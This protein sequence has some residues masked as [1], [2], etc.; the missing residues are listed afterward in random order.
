MN[1]EAESYTDP[2]VHSPGFRHLPMLVD[3][4]ARNTPNKTW[5]SIPIDQSDVSAGF[6]DISY[7]EFNDAIS[8][9][10]HWLA[11]ILDTTENLETVAY[12][13]PR[14]IRYPILAMAMAKLEKKLMLPSPIAT[15]EAQA[16]LLREMEC[17]T[18]LYGGNLGGIV[19]GAAAKVQEWKIKVLEVPELDTWLKA[20]KSEP[21]KWRKS[22][23][24]ARH[25]PWIVTHSSGSTGLPKPMA[26]THQMMTSFEATELMPDA[27]E[28][29]L[30]KHMEGRRCYSPIATLHVSNFCRVP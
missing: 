17:K 19:H 12:A 13:G 28:D 25:L 20:E 16:Y 21:V 1:G 24:E 26:Y 7:R 23:E 4:Y 14:D 5:A 9:Y 27:N 3:Y 22:W 30:M 15:L 10:A 11:N 8:Y 2:N 18:F 6:R 29:S